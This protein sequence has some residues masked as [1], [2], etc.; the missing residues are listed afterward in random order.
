MHPDLQ[1]HARQAVDRLRRV[2][3]RGPAATHGEIRSAVNAVVE[4]RNAT[5]ARNSGG[6]ASDDCL[7]RA[8]A[9]VS[10]AYGAEFPLSG[11]HFRRIEQVC[12]GMSRML[13]ECA[14]TS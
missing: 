6:E 1:H 13:A 4:F 9:L 14:S 11:L 10:L 3:D 12:E 7:D 8:N 5:L 2:L